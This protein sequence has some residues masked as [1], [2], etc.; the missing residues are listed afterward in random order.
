MILNFLPES[1]TSWQYSI[2]AN[3][4]FLSKTP[5]G[6]V[7]LEPRSLPSLPWQGH[8]N[9]H[10]DPRA[11]S[12]LLPATLD[13]GAIERHIIF[14][15]GFRIVRQRLETKEPV[16]V[17]D[18]VQEC[19]RWGCWCPGRARVGRPAQPMPTPELAPS[20][21]HTLSRGLRN[22]G[23]EIPTTASKSK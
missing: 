7:Q 3:P 15:S 9:T 11:Q 2:S 1:P 17:W 16:Q 22:T 4:P 13:S 23:S 20:P 5:R 12:L 8:R 21:A 18:Q 10:K 19:S 6:E 14:R